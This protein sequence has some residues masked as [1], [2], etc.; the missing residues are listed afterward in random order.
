VSKGW[1]KVLA[2]RPGLDRRAKSSTRPTSRPRAGLL[3]FKNGTPFLN[4]N[5]HTP[6]Y[7]HN[8]GTFKTGNQDAKDG[9]ARV[10]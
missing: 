9:G 5:A 10:W 8:A 4:R 3:H 6:Q 2:G 7:T 1:T